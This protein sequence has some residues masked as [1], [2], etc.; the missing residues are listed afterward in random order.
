MSDD[1]GRVDIGDFL[2]RRPERLF[3]VGRLDADTEGLLLLTND[4]DLAHRLQHPRHGVSKTYLAQVR[5]P[6]ARDVGR[7]L[8]EGVE[9]EDGP[10]AVD[11]FR[12]VDSM[13]GRAL[14]EVVIHEGRNHVVRR[15]LDAVGHPVETLVRTQVGPVRLGDTKPG[16]WRTLTPAEV[17]DLYRAA[18]L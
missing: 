13:P 7:R 18:G 16:K 8:R 2:G 11:S 9:L 12:I 1:L 4:G 15:L 14:V 3:H 10:V 6:V 17:G 5:G